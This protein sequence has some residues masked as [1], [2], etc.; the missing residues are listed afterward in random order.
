MNQNGKLLIII[1]NNFKKVEAN[2]TSTI[3]E[4]ANNFA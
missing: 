4:I 1:Y 3:E 2:N